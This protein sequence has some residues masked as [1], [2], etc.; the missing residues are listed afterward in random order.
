MKR[1]KFVLSKLLSSDQ[2]GFL[3]G[4]YIGENTRLIYDLMNYVEEDILPGLLLIVDFKK[5]FDSKSLE[6]IGKVFDFFKFGPSIKK[7]GSR[8][9]IIISH[10]MLNKIRILRELKLVMSSIFYHN[11]LMI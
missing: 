5:A 1:L 6:F 11:S 2:T 10:L 9:Y 3:S 4:R 7:N 8:Y